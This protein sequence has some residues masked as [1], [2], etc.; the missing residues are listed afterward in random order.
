MTVAQLIEKLEQ[1][2]KNA[3]VADYVSFDW[4]SSGFVEATDVSYMEQ[5]IHSNYDVMGETYREKVVFLRS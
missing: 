2:P 5:T 4:D 1:L 3:K